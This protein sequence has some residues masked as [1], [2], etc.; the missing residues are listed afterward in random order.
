MPV[1][2]DACMHQV[3]YQVVRSRSVPGESE[4][5]L[6]D[7]VAL[8]LYRLKS[9]GPRRKVLV[10]LTDGEHNVPDPRSGWTPRQAAHEGRGEGTCGYKG[11]EERR[12]QE[13]GGYQGRDSSF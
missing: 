6:S 1:N 5:N 7:A 10:L 3:F 2:I 12:V 4:T 13:V 8:G 9:A 11:F